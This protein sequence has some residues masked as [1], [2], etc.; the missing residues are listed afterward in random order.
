MK[1]FSIVTVI[2]VLVFF[3]ITARSEPTTADM[4]EYTA[5]TLLTNTCA[6]IK[7]SENNSHNKAFFSK[8]YLSILYILWFSTKSLNPISDELLASYFRAFKY[9][10]NTLDFLHLINLEDPLGIDSLSS[11]E[12]SNARLQMNAGSYWDW[13]FAKNTDKKD[14]KKFVSDFNDC[15]NKTK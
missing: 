7:D 3:S 9:N 5:T 14:Y 1:A 15:L 4:L 13:V 11:E 10:A 8:Q 2:S 12:I 6:L